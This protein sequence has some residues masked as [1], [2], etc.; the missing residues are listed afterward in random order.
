MATLKKTIGKILGKV[1]SSGASK[2][3]LLRKCQTSMAVLMDHK[4][5]DANFI[6][7]MCTHPGRAPQLVIGQVYGTLALDLHD[8][9]FNLRNI[10]F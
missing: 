3:S 8:T 6:E 7:G 1:Y 9:L 10:I 4:G 2:H 5:L